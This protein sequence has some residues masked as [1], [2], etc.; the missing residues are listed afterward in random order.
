RLEREVATDRATRDL[1]REATEN[2]NLET[3][4]Q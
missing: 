3:R 4:P 2:L 1:V